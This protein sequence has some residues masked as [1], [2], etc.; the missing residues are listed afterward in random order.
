MVYL[1]ENA[2]L[3]D[4]GVVTVITLRNL[5]PVTSKSSRLEPLT[6]I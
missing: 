1:Q 4:G 5:K 2:P 6:L 3:R